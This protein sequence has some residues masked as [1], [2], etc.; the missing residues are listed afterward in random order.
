[1]LEDFAVQSAKKAKEDLEKSELRN[2]LEKLEKVEMEKSQKDLRRFELKERLRELK[3]AQFERIRKDLR[4]SKEKREKVMFTFLP[5]FMIF[6]L[7][8]ETLN[9][10][11]QE[12][13]KEIFVKL[14]EKK[15]ELNEKKSFI[16]QKKLL[17]L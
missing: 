17:T 5:L 4:K 7:L 12:E 8:K 6:L 16:L 9:F 10:Q 3:K 11:F 13:W 2:Q 14:E 15:G 1:M